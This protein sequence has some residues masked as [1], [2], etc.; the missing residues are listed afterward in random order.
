MRAP[1]KPRRIRRAV[2][3]IAFIVTGV[4]IAIAANGWWQARQD[5]SR[6][7]VYLRQLLADTRENERQILTAILQDSLLR[8]RTIRMLQVF[9][10]RMPLPPVDSIVRWHQWSSGGG[11]SAATGTYEVLL[12]T[13]G[14]RLLHDDSVRAAL[15]DFDSRLRS[16]GRALEV[17]QM[18]AGD[19]I[20]IR[21]GR[22]IAYLPKKNI[23]AAGQD[24]GPTQRRSDTAW[25]VDVNWGEYRNDRA[26][27]TAFQM[28][29]YLQNNNLSRLKPLLKAAQR[30]RRH[31]EA[32]LSS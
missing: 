30:L 27:H 24:F 28:M 22:M 25:Q 5:R 12:R 31:L 7:A 18:R 14:I 21:T 10:S 8:E 29:T 20:S 6:E 19:L 26:A 23:D 11:I 4:L 32:H 1:L 13:D 9:R 17:N 15:I 16:T 3:E 2:S